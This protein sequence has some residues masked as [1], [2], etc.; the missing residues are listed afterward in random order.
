MIPP[1]SSPGGP[2][3]PPA[4]D[5]L[6]SS[7]PLLPVLPV[8]C[9]HRLCWLPAGPG[10][11]VRGKA[12]ALGGVRGLWGDCKGVTGTVVLPLRL[13]CDAGLENARLLVVHRVFVVGKMLTRRP[14][15]VPIFVQTDA[16]NISVTALLVFAGA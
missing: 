7:S 16:F 13:G 15:L 3:A 12:G 1:T 2:A 11:F 8:V 14:E 10:L 9:G 6:A 4:R 5:L